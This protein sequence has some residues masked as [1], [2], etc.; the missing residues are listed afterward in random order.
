[1]VY[2]KETQF[3]ENIMEVYEDTDENNNRCVVIRVEN[4]NIFEYW[5]PIMD[6]E[7]YH[8]S[9]KILSSIHMKVVEI[10]SDNNNRTEYPGTS[11]V[12][13]PKCVAEK[14]EE[15]SGLHIPP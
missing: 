8:N 6:G 10:D 2:I 1:M 11:D 5:F 15:Y 7:S 12:T 13:V 4:S 3:N 9:D 14:A